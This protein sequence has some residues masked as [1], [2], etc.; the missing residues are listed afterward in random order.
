MAN[1]QTGALRSLHPPAN[2]RATRGF[3]FGKRK[4][5]YAAVSGER[6][7]GSSRALN[8]ILEAAG[9]R[10]ASLSPAPMAGR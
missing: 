4:A 9:I 8:E 5:I 10:P 2:A 7:R 1:D 3:V 6:G